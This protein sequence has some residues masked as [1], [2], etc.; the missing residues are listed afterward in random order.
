MDPRTN[1]NVKLLKFMTIYYMFYCKNRT[2][3]GKL[4]PWGILLFNKLN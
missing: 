2:P 4:I 1:S 3:Q